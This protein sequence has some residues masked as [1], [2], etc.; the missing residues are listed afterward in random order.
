MA[1][2]RIRGP[3]GS[4]EIAVNGL[5]IGVECSG[6]CRTYGACPAENREGFVRFANFVRM[7]TELN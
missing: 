7:S 3:I 2:A 1:G 4:V 6:E 5:K